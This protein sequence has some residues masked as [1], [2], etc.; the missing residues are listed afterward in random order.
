MDIVENAKNIA[1]E[2]HKDVK[3]KWSPAPYFVHPERC[4]KLAK[5]LGYGE[6]LQATMFL[7]DVVEDAGDGLAPEERDRLKKH[8]SE[9]IKKECGLEVLV[10][11]MELTFPT[12]GEEWKHRARAEKN[13]IREAQMRKMSQL[14]QV[15]KMIDSY[16]NYGDMEHAPKRLIQKTMDDG[17]A[18]YDILKCA[19]DK[20]A[21]LLKERILGMSKFMKG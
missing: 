21:A 16:D 13:V 20:L 4:A 9:R 6:V 2:A 17:W 12:E 19:D 15:G 8:Y 10:L 11:V 14:A 3:R 7:H 1:L 5:E 18:R